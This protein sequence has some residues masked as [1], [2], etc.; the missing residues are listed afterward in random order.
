[1]KFSPTSRREERDLYVSVYHAYNLVLLQI[2]PQ[3]T[4]ST[5]ELIR[6]KVHKINQDLLHFST[7][8]FWGREIRNN[9]TNEYSSKMLKF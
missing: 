5:T 8:L 9:N 3:T 7:A 6:I 4:Q 1:M 2:I